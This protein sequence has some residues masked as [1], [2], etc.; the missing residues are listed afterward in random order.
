MSSRLLIISLLYSTTV[1]SVPFTPNNNDQ[2]LEQLPKAANAINKELRSLRDELNT[3]PQQLDVAVQLAKRYIAVGK[4][5]ADPRYYG[6]AQGVLKP[7]WDKPEPASEVLLVRALILQNRH[8]FANALRDLDSLLR[9]EP[10]NAEAWLTQA[11]ILQV[12]ARY[13]EAQRSCLPLI[14]LDVPL[15]ASTCLASLGSLTGQAEKSYVFLQKTLNEAQKP[16]ADQQLWALTVLAEI[17]TRIGKIKEAEQF[18]NAALKVNGRDVYLLS[19]YSDF[20]LD[21]QRPADVIA[22]LADK[23]RIDGL[24]LRS[25][26]AKQQMADPKLV[27][28]IAELQ[29]R[30]AASYLRGENLHQGDEA[31]F[32]LHLLKQPQR[33]LQLALANWQVQREP[34]DTRILLEVAIA[35][36]NSV[37]A[38]PALDLLKTTGMESLVL[39]QLMQQLENKLP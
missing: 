12:T 13:D 15:V 32:T 6:Y 36:H 19:A 38:Q 11:I 14:T 22:L 10:D 2:V 34:K 33:A 23:T 31:R 1:I 8:D 37:T 4:A 39:K 35:E 24:F 3:H 26:L 30:F 27:E 20:L 21:Q 18:F 25:V 5:E 9:R 28:L 7:W 16:T 17:A 29:A